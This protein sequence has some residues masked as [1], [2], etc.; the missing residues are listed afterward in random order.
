MTGTRNDFRY[1]IISANGSGGN[2]LLTDLISYWTMNEVTGAARGDSADTNPLSDNGGVV[3][4]P[5]KIA[6][7]AEFNGLTQYLSAASSAG[8]QTGDVS[9]ALSGWLNLTSLPS[10][11]GHIYVVAGKASGSAVEYV[12]YV[13]V[14]DLL[15]LQVWNGALSAN[16]TLLALGTLPILTWKHF[17]VQRNKDT[18]KLE[19]WIDGASQGDAP[20]TLAP[21]AS[22]APLEVGRY[23]FT[24]DRFLMGSVDE[25]GFWKRALTAAE[26]SLLYNG[27]AGLA[28]PF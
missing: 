4:L 9:F 6:N 15:K 13:D 16:D 17:V 5:G 3:G 12:V 27:G 21:A 8:L 7:A 26:V 20:S 24:G 1:D 14:D 22:A 11:V 2:A 19:M 28:Y 10:V 18:N 23:G 25:L